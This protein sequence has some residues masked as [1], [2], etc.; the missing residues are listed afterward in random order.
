MMEKFIIILK[1]VFQMSSLLWKL[2]ILPSFDPMAVR[3]LMETLGFEWDQEKEA[4]HIPIS[5][6][7]SQESDQN[8]L[9][10]AFDCFAA[11]VA[12][13][14]L[15]EI[16]DL[17]ST[18]ERVAVHWPLIIDVRRNCL[19]TVRELMPVLLDKLPRLSETDPILRMDWELG[20]TEPD[21]EHSISLN[22]FSQRGLQTGNGK[23][24]GAGDYVSSR[25]INEV[26]DPFHSSTLDSKPHSRFSTSSLMHKISDMKHKMAQSFHHNQKYSSA[27][28]QTFH[29][30]QKYSP[31][32]VGSP[33]Q[34]P[35][36]AR[37]G[38][39]ESSSSSGLDVKIAPI[40]CPKCG[41]DLDGKA[42][43]ICPHCHKLFQ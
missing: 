13:E 31:A 24:F 8:L 16:S 7:F 23:N 5:K 37:L 22:E 17:V 10:F 6:L 20:A 12:C 34:D 28:D 2:R 1:L 27:P 43:I 35:S 42:K 29:Q 38:F 26:V 30:N 41:M 40:C 33:N 36:S 32:P 9:E 15:R 3:E 19:G 25:I 14:E 4:W 11:Q 21:S 18:Q 39:Y